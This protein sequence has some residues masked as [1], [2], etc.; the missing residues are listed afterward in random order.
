[1][2]LVHS[3][4]LHPNCTTPFYHFQFIDAIVLQEQ[5]WLLVAPEWI[6]VYHPL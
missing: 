2:T 5:T 4:H 3:C 6:T 1:M